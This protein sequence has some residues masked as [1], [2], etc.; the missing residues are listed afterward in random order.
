MF[1]SIEKGGTPEEAT[2]IILF[3]ASL[4]SNHV[5]GQVI[6]MTGVI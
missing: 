6:G 5:S 4:L 1:N 2:G 3:L